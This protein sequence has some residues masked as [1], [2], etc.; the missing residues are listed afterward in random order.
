VALVVILRISWLME[1]RDLNF[2]GLK[3]GSET[4]QIAIV[5]LAVS[6]I[7]VRFVCIF[8]KAANWLYSIPLFLGR[9]ISGGTIWVQ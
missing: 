7:K 4:L 2:G 8:E 1:R 3:V 5:F 9:V 6:V